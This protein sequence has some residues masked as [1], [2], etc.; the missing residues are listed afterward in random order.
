M[1]SNT[2]KGIVLL[3]AVLISLVV[4]FQVNWLTKVYTLEQ[5][6]FSGKV[7]QVV[8]NLQTKLPH[9]FLKNEE[10]QFYRIDQAVEFGYLV[11][12]KTVADS[13]QLRRILEESFQ[14][15]QVNA[16]GRA[17]IVQ[18]NSGEVLFDHF[19]FPTVSSFSLQD[20]GS[21]VAFPRKNYPYLLLHFPFRNRYILE[22]MGF[23]IISSS[24]LF[25]I[26]LAFCAGLFILYRQKFTQELQKDFINNIAHEFRTP[27]SVLR[28]ASEVLLSNQDTQNQEKQH[29]Y[30]KIIYE[31]AQVL[32]KNIHNLLQLSENVFK[33]EKGRVESVYLNQMVESVLQELDSCIQATHNTIQ[34][35]PDN[36]LPPLKIDPFHLRTVII[37]ILE[38]ALKYAPG[39]VIRLQTL[40]NKNEQLLCIKDYGQGIEK[41]HHKKIF[42]RFYRISQG[43]L[44]DVKGFG[45]GLFTAQQMTKLYRGRIEVNSERGM[46]SEFIVYLPNSK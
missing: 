41:E 25:L 34:W 14:T 16:R 1:K 22:E 33:R 43:D 9:L 28:I 42:Q 30:T 45:L 5:R 19:I 31:Q 46:G 6:K 37:A 17:T 3:L 29:K 20:K 15:Y 32:E 18:A 35:Q 24:A 7:S 26:L 10:G 11:P 40:F 8:Q 13:S 39:S 36:G 12:L 2:I 21:E 23:W 44:H 27:V 38:N 4:F